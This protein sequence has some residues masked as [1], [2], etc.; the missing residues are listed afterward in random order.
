KQVND[1]LGHLA[2]DEL[3][4]QAGAR[5]RQSVRAEDLVARL[6]GDEF[7]VLCAGADREVA[8]EVAA[9]VTHAFERPFR[10][11]GSLEVLGISIGIGH[12]PDHLDGDTLATADRDLYEAK[13]A[14]R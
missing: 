3:L 6:G 1:R 2:G 5:L 4:R 7:A 14:R 8:V 13:R 9:R 10:I 11:M 12:A